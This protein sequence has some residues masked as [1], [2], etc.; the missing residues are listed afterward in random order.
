[1]AKAARE[2]EREGVDA[3]M[4]DCGFMA[5]FQKALQESVRVPVFSSSLL[6]VPLVARMIPEGKR[7]GILTY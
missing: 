5:L 6:L 4:G 3:I 2:L 1:M 7:V